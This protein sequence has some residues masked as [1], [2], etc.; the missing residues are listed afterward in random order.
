MSKIIVMLDD[1]HDVAGSKPTT[2]IILWNLLILALS[3]KDQR[4]SNWGPKQ[5]VLQPGSD[6]LWNL[7]VYKWI[8]ETI[9]IGNIVGFIRQ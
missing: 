6:F 7:H 4:N 2:P 1:H 8:E 3:L 9:D 5:R